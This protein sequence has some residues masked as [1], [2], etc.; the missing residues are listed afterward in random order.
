M[1]RHI[2]LQK[3][4]KKVITFNLLHVEHEFEF[5]SGHNML[6]FACV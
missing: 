2:L 6:L 3:Q 1:C 4:N 5:C